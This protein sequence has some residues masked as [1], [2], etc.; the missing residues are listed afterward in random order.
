MY[1]AGWTLDLVYTSHLQTAGPIEGEGAYEHGVPKQAV[2]KSRLG[3][4]DLGPW[5]VSAPK[6]LQLTEEHL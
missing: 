3:M 6:S 2:S 1:H 5:L 4:Q